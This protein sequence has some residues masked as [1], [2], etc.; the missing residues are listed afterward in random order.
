M[1]EPSGRSWK[2]NAETPL[3]AAEKWAKEF[4]SR[5]P[6][7]D[8]EHRRVVVEDDRGDRT[9]ALVGA[10]VRLEFVA[11]DPNVQ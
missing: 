7:M 10:I 3:H 1:T 4:H 6:W 2:C 8:G 11:I 9:V 5:D